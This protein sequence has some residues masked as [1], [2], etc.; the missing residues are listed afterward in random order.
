MSPAGGPKLPVGLTGF[1]LAKALRQL[2]FKEVDAKGSHVK[3]Q[4]DGLRPFPV[5]LHKTPIP[6][7]TLRAILRQADLTLQELLGAL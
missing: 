5:A 6:A 4:R 1:Q 7:G 2:G 3:F